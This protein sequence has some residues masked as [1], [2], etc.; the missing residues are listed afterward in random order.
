MYLKT[1]CLIICS[2]PAVKFWLL[3][4]IMLP[5]AL[6]AQDAK[7]LEQNFNLLFKN[8]PVSERKELVDRSV[9]T[10]ASFTQ[11]ERDSVEKVLQRL[12]ELRVTVN[13]ELKNYLKCVN[14]FCSRGEKENL[15]VW[16]EGLKRKQAV[17]ENRRNAIRDYLQHVTPVVCEQ[18]LVASANH[19]WLVRGKMVWESGEPGPPEI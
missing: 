4:F 7:T 9:E 19:K 17:Q 12:Q 13:P 18:V 6:H 1:N 2:V 10:W 8:L 11:A 5:F 3:A 15:Q 16:L 14:A